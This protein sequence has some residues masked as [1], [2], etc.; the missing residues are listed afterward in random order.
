MSVKSNFKLVDGIPGWGQD[1]NVVTAELLEDRIV[2]SK[3]AIKDS[4]TVSLLLEQIVETNVYTEKE[5]LEKS[6]S[7]V[8]RA[9]V[10]SLF[11]P[12]GALIGAVS[13]TGTKKR[14]KTDMFYT[15][16]FNSSAGTPSL[17]VLRCGCMGCHWSEFDSALTAA[18]PPKP[19]N[20]FL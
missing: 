13:G 19:E 1:I 8:G 20:V 4:P 14:V 9:A 6:K 3:A 15:I 7:V 5:I 11:G 17:I 16:M 10:G 12:V 2:F 18:L